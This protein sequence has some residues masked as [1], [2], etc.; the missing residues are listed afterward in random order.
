LLKELE[1]LIGGGAVQRFHT[2]Q[3]IKPNTVAEH[4][5]GVAMLVDLL[6][7]GTASKNL[8]VAALRHDMAEQ[9]T[10]D[11][12]AP[13]KRAYGLREQ[14]NAIEEAIMEGSHWPMPTLTETEKQV[15]K[16]ADCLD[17]ALYCIREA[18]IG[19]AKNMQ[20]CYHNFWSYIRELAL[21]FDAVMGWPDQR[22]LKEVM[23]Y[24]SKLGK[25]A[26]LVG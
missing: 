22:V 3:T 24:T 5:F 18:R 14:V 15:L 8:V 4:S 19:N 10:G 2:V 1:F 6:T 13:A 23:F 7:G 11:I 20:P 25:E 9:T 16:F 12:P 17:G 21:P 26:G